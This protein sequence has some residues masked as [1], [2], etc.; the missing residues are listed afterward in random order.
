M[1]KEIEAEKTGEKVENN[2]V[3]KRKKDGVFYTPEYITKYIV[4]NTIGKLCEEKRNELK[5]TDENIS[6]ATGWE[7]GQELNEEFIEQLTEEQK[8]AGRLS[9]DDEGFSC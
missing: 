8:K 1:Q 2:N 3:G 5:I 9:F 6:N 4:E 7:I